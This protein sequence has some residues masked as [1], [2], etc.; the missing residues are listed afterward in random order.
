MDLDHFRKQAARLRA[1]WRSSYSDERL[2]LF[3]KCFKHEENEVFA[4]AVTDLILN[5]RQ[6]PMLEELTQA[7]EEAKKR[8]RASFSPG[9]GETLSTL[10][11]RY[12][13]QAKNVKPEVVQLAVKLVHAYAGGHRT[14][15]TAQFWE[16]HAM[17]CDIAGTPKPCSVCHYE[18]ARCQCAPAPI[19]PASPHCE[20]E[21]P[22]Y[23]EGVI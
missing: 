9:G 6:A 19:L 12:A 22:L 1:Q 18:R 17:L 4:D 7:V 16:G 11:S 23:E 10:F 8:V 14:I 21:A 5:R 3:W 20:G 2:N 13:E 15:T